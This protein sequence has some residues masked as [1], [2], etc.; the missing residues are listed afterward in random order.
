MTILADYLRDNTGKTHRIYPNA[1]G[2]LVITS[3]YW[4]ESWTNPTYAYGSTYTDYQTLAD[5]AGNTWYIYLNTEGEYTEIVISD[6]APS[7]NAGVW[8]DPVYETGKQAPTEATTGDEIYMAL[9]TS[10]GADYYVY[11]NS[12]GELVITTTE[13]S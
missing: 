11:P 8:L 3:D 5:S 12:D 6:T 7:S 10:G 13:P 4:D 1:D 2:E 9:Q